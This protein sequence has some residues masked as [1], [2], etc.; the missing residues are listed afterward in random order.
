MSLKT[1][2]QRYIALLMFF[3]DYKVVIYCFTILSLSVIGSKLIER[4]VF[5]EI[6]P[7]A[8]AVGDSLVPFLAL[9]IF[10][11]VSYSV[12]CHV[13]F[14]TTL[15]KSFL[16][17]TILV[18]PLLYLQF[19]NI[20]ENIQ[21][22]SGFTG[23]NVSISGTV[24]SQE[25]SN[26]YLFHSKRGGMGNSLI[27]FNTYP[28]LHV[29]Q[30]CKIYGKVVQPKVF[31][32]FDY[33]K[34]LFR[35]G[36]YS[37]IEVQ[38]YECNGV[39]NIFLESRYTLER[40]VEKALPEPEASLLIGVMFGSKRVFEK[41]FNDALN[42]S[43][44]SHVIAASG[45]NVAL[46]AQGINFIMKSRVGKVSTMIKILCIW[47]FSIFS[48]LSSSLVRASTMSSISLFAN[49]FG[50]EGNKGGAL[51][52]C[53]TVLILINP[54]L[55]YDVGFLFSFASVVGLIYFPKCFESLK[56]K[57]VKENVL[58]TLTC[59]LFTLP[60]SVMFFGKVSIIS[61]ISNIVILPIIG[62]TIFWGLGITVVNIFFNLKL[63]YVIPYIQLSIFKY[64]V[65]MTS[66][67]QMV[68][69]GIDGYIF[70]VSV[71]ILLLLFCLY[72]Y[73]VSSNNYYLL[74]SKKI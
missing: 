48:G 73:P 22:V 4:V 1:L 35:K 8:R 43:G 38:E 3:I 9:E 7:C 37:I 16:L 17:S 47:I 70:A 20:T 6:E 23:K 57:F 56:S 58:P 34:Y 10:I 29:G 72:R 15:V 32:D 66:N 69:I 71:Y 42:K 26:T 41:D 21:N 55:I 30:T 54:F 51:V 40:V 46:V 18:V 19:E 68:E 63:L 52:L 24:M 65:L 49:L 25:K 28:V 13:Y 31:E 33:R 50:R 74:L 44:V 45:Y 62:S 5:G 67:I 36:I 27:R 64:F 11:F 39:G 60:I 53:A 14:F 59:I 12:F 61:L 2:K